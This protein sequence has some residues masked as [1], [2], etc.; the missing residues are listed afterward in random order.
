MDGIIKHHTGSGGT[1]HYSDG[2]TVFVGNI[3][4]TNVTQTEL[5]E[6][7]GTLDTN[8]I[9]G[10]KYSCGASGAWVENGQGVQVYLTIEGNKCGP[11]TRTPQPDGTTLLGCMNSNQY[12]CSFV[13]P[14]EGNKYRIYN[15][16]CY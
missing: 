15:M 8:Y 2:H 3:I 10:I 7:G 16:D 1:V 11:F 5:M 13:L 14:G 12:R 9:G 6:T 4:V